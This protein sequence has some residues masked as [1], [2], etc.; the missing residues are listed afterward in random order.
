MNRR[1]YIIGVV[2]SLTPNDEG[3]AEMIVDRLIE[4]GVLHLGYGNTEVDA[5]LENFTKAFGNTKTTKWDR[6]A[7]HRLAGK[8]GSQA[9]V[10]IIQLLAQNSTEK[11]APTVGSVAQLEEKIVA[12]LSFLRKTSGNETL[13]I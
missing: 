9:V 4:E 1:E 6:W 5:I 7:A 12:V 3:A 11:Y 13:D 10:G 2:R 8:Y